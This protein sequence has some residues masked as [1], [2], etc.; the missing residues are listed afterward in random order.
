LSS[1]ALGTNKDMRSSKSRFTLTLKD[2]SQELQN[3]A[4]ERRAD[5]PEWEKTYTRTG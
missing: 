1:V 3:V 5:R 2:I 4:K